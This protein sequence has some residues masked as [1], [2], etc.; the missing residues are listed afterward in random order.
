MQFL[1]PNPNH[2]P[3]STIGNMALRTVDVD[4]MREDEMKIFKEKLKVYRIFLRVSEKKSTNAQDKDE[5]SNFKAGI[6][7]LYV[8]A[9]SSL[10]PEKKLVKGIGTSR[11]ETYAC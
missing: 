9:V 8:E 7:M 10:V 2:N 5:F 11:F 6:L 1:A 4:L 3:P